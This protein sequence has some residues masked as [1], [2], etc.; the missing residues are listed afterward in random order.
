MYQLNAVNLDD[1]WQ[2]DQGWDAERKSGRKFDDKVELDFW[3]KLAPTYSKQ[4]NLYRDSLILQDKLKGV[5]G[6]GRKIIDVGCGSGNFSI[7]LSK[8]SKEI[9][10]LDFSPAMLEQLAI[11]MKQEKRENIR[12]ICSKWEDFAEDYPADFVLAVNSLYR[13]CYMRQVLSKISAYGRKGFVIVRTLLRPQM[14][15]L[16][17]DLGLSYRFNNDYILVPM[18]L[19]DMGINANVEYITYTRR[20]RYND[21]SEVEAEMKNDLGELSFLNF[22]DQLSEKFMQNV[23]EEKNG[24]AYDSKRVVQIISYIKER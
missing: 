9:L 19:W 5:F 7:P 1:L 6:E 10:A 21:F 17:R 23:I 2:K 12:M 4:Y 20:K 22:N 8:Y 13:V 18:M 16:Y 24:F 15:E 14:Y 3:E 11:S